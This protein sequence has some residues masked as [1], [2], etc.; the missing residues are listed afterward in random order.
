MRIVLLCK[1]HYT[2]QDLISNRFGRLYHLPIQLGECGHEGLVVAADYLRGDPLEIEHEGVRFRSIPASAIGFSRY[3]AA[4][5]RITRRFKPDVMI[6]SSDI[7]FGWLGARTGRRR[8]V[9][10]VYDLYDNYEAFSSAKIPGMR[11]AHRK[12]LRAADLV[13]CVG[14]PLEKAV[15]P[16]ARRTM[17]IP[18]GV[19]IE[20]FRPIDRAEARSSA[21]VDGGHG[22]IGYFGSMQP[23]HDVATLIAAV[24]GLRED[25]LDLRLLLAGKVVVDLDLD[26]RWIDSRGLVAQARIP[27]LINA[28]DVAVIP[29]RRD[30]WSDFTNAN[31]LFEY[32]ACEVPIVTTRVSDY[33][34]HAAK[35]EA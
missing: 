28:C 17:I 11:A 31:K 34:R 23:N 25:G 13:T 27:E 4:V 18:N 10:F 30:R 5:E 24:A 2:N 15:G 21:N 9:P 26:R 32:A 33:E 35:P 14:A 20:L 16:H 12:A 7:P 6:A 8:G 1:R 22:V 19:D 3:V 29:Y